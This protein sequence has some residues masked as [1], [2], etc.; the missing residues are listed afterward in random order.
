MPL[1]CSGLLLLFVG[2]ILEGRTA[3]QHR[4]RRRGRHD[5]EE[6]EALMYRKT[7]VS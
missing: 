2:N 4:G 5:Y 3:P 6:Y 7:S 1:F